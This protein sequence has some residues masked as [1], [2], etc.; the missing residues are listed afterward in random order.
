MYS[1]SKHGV[2]YLLKRGGLLPLD[3]AAPTCQT[4]HMQGG[5]HGVRAAW[6]FLAVR[7]PLPEDTQWADDRVTILKALRVLDTEG[8][9]TWRLGA[10]K[11]ADLARLT[12]EAWQKE[13]DKMT[14]V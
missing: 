12:Q 6:G 3:M 5:D 8:N 13:R 1:G 2:R 9:P 14:A 4:C 10:V 11:A 7:L